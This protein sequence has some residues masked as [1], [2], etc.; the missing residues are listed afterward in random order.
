MGGL[1][2]ADAPLTV[3]DLHDLFAGMVRQSD[4]LDTKTERTHGHKQFAK[5]L[6][7]GAKTPP[8]IG[9]GRLT[10]LSED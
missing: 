5:L 7:R 1:R 2:N 9:I 6:G 3:I 4:L 8:V 10:N